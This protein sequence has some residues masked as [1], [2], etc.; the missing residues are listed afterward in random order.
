MAEEVLI[1][2]YYSNNSHGI[3]DLF[4]SAMQLGYL[5]LLKILLH[6]PR[7]PQ[8]TYAGGAGTAQ[9]TP[10]ALALLLKDPHVNPRNNNVIG[11]YSYYGYVENVALL[12]KDGRADPGAHDNFAIRWATSHGNVKV[13]K[14]LLTDNRVDPATDNNCVIKMASELGYVEIVEL[15]LEKL[16]HKTNITQY[17]NLNISKSDIKKL[18]EDHLIKYRWIMKVFLEEFLTIDLLDYMNQLI[19]L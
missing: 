4:Y 19:K 13:V 6:D 8:N 12:L 14:L 3:G 5:K 18:W 11:W 9:C 2:Q 17:I 7:L 16:K 1:Q 10:E 15:L